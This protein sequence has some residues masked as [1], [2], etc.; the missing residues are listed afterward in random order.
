MIKISKRK[1]GTLQLILSGVMITCL[2]RSQPETPPFVFEYEQSHI[3]SAGV[4]DEASGIADSRSMPGSLW[5]Q[6]DGN[7]PNQLT[8]L[9]YKGELKGRIKL[10]FP[11]RD[12]EDVD[13]IFDKKDS[14]NYML[15]AD[16][17]DNLRQFAE[18]YI[19]RFLEPQ[20]VNDE[21][22]DFQRI[23]FYYPEGSRDTEA[24]LTD[25]ITQ[26]IY[27]ITKSPGFSKLYK[28]A[29][30]QSFDK[31]IPAMYVCDLPM[32]Q[33]TSG[34]FS[35]DGKQIILR[36][37]T[38]LYLWQ[39]DNVNEPIQDVI[40]SSYKLMLPYVFEPQGEAVCF[41]KNGKGYFTLSEKL[42]HLPTQLF[43]F[44]KRE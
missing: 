15:I 26:D 9:S 6:E 24:I 34:D 21:V 7:N 5:V 19:Y 40:Y 20:S 18:Y 28:L 22:E 30:P 31:P 39:R 1:I 14:T 29:Y 16:T 33:V 11:N 3:I 10:P 37:Y 44:A 17:G 2:T 8:L 42:P 43:Y 12:W 41:E 13:T 4:V 25:P 36:N 35:P 27:V 32:Y 23:T 38:T